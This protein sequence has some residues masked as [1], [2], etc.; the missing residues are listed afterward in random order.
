MCHGGSAGGPLPGWSQEQPA[1]DSIKKLFCM[2]SE[3]HLKVQ[4]GQLEHFRYCVEHHDNQQ[5]YNEEAFQQWL[6][7]QQVR[8]IWKLKVGIR[9]SIIKF[10]IKNL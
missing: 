7:F 10:C 4:M 9:L 5:D 3:H 6:G 2:W 1:K 8:S